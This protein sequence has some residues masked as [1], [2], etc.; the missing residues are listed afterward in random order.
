MAASVRMTNLQVVNHVQR[1]L[2]VNP[3]NA[4][5]TTR[6]SIMLTQLLN[7]VI[8]EVNDYGRWQ[9]MYEEVIVTAQTSVRTYSIASATREVESIIEV[10]FD[11]DP[12]QLENR[13]IEDIRRLRRVGSTGTPRQ[14][15]IIGVDV[16]GNPQMEVFPFPGTSQNGKTF[17]VAI[18]AKEPLYTTADV[19]AI[20]T[21]PGNMLVQGLYAKALLEEN[22]G[23]TSRQF[24]AAYREFQNMVRQAQ[25]R[26]TSDTEDN[27][28]F[29]PHRF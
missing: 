10:S 20:P 17:N 5:V 29:V 4:L 9:E 21:Y 26:F 12:A 28:Q 18:Q 6:H 7:E 1:R 24:E 13:P 22:G 8:A 25:R 11:D 3:T 23:E 19:S 15:A 27:L 2:G 16:S 14:Y